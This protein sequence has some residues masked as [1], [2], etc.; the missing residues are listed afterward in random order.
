MVG[1]EIQDGNISG[2]YFENLEIRNLDFQINQKD[3]IVDTKIGSIKLYNTAADSM[4]L[5]ELSLKSKIEKNKNG[6]LTDSMLESKKETNK[7]AIMKTDALF[8]NSKF[9]IL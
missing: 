1:F 8:D 4:L 7:T 2:S 3:N 9:F 5:E 6:N